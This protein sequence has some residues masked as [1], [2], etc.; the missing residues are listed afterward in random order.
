M[1][2]ASLSFDV[3]EEGGKRVLHAGLGLVPCQM[4]GV[5]PYQL[6]KRPYLHPSL[7]PEPNNG[8]SQGLSDERHPTVTADSTVD[9]LAQAVDMILD[10]RR[11][12]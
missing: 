6:M 8:S 1:E 5:S 7:G 4:D 12:H 3:M 2:W 9:N 11:R 10:Q